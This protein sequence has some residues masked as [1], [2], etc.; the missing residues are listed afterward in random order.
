[1][2]NEEI[3]EEKDDFNFQA[4]ISINRYRLDEESEKQ[5]S[6]YGRYA[7]LL[8]DAK[9][10]KDSAENALKLKMA[11]IEISLRADPSPEVKITENSI[12]A[13]IVKNEKVVK[14][15]ERLLRKEAVI[16]KLEAAVRALDHRK[17]ELNNLTQL[18][19]KGYYSQ[20]NDGRPH[21]T[22]NDVAAKDIRK[23]LN[24][25]ERS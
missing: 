4:D 8:A 21:D 18:W 22:G 13:L 25:K 7:E 19:I 10:D 17:S 9:A 11:E 3:K 1:M 5:P 24:N 6:I 2:E 14:K 12:K 15:K 20:P 16:Y 23:N